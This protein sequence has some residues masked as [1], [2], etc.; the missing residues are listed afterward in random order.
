M[1]TEGN[2]SGATAGQQFA[3][4]GRAPPAVVRREVGRVRPIQLND[5]P[6]VAQA[7]VPDQRRVVRRSAPVLM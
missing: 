5:A 2:L 7:E 4:A 3:D 6:P 1:P